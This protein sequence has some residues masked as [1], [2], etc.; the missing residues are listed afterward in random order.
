MYRVHLVLEESFGHRLFD[1]P[2]REPV[3]IT[4]TPGNRE[5]VEERWKS[6]N[7]EDYLHGVTT[8][9]PAV[10]ERPAEEIIRLLPTI[11]EHHGE[12]AHDPPYDALKIHGFSD[13]QAIDAALREYGFAFHEKGE[14]YCEFRRPNTESGS[15]EDLPPRPPTTGHTGP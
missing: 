9:R 3:W 7:S 6:P 1:L 10:P 4:D 5:A 15:G 8:Y 2:E 14:D 11:E 13:N 12:F